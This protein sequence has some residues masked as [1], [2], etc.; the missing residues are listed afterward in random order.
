MIW[1][2]ER[3]S[4]LIGDIYDA[5]LDPSLWRGALR[6]IA[7]FVGGSASSICTTNARSVHV[8][9]HYHW[10]LQQSFVQ[11]Y[12]DNYVKCDPAAVGQF[13]F[14]VEDVY[15]FVDFLPLEEL[16]ETRF[17]KECLKPEGWIDRIGATLDKSATSFAA[18]V[19]FRNEQE[20]PVDEN[21][22]RRMR[23][24]VPHIRRAVLVGNVVDLHKGEASSLTSLFDSL[25][26]GVLL[27][28]ADAR[29]VFT[30]TAARAMLGEGDI[31]RDHGGKL[32]AID[33]AADRTLRDV[34]AA[35][36]NGDA[37]VGAEGVALPLSSASKEQWLA[38]ILPL[39]SGERRRAGSEHS[40]TAAVFVRKAQLETP[41]LMK[42]V[43]T[44]YR[45]TPTEIR[46]LQAL[47]EIGGVPSVA[48]ALGVSQ[49]TIR[50]HL[51]NLFAKTG[52][53][54]QADL[55]KLIASHSSPFNG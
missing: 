4:R 51:K 53:R 54:R 10:G 29:I 2:A 31:L 50:T 52:M 55:V 3:F 16:L 13:V 49:T 14:D 8:T 47:V 19:V 33:T 12:F 44:L 27:V 37:G 30:N 35:T 5:A 45:L 34:F 36:P 1:E 48:E 22:R 40:A 11:N 17:Y 9:S 43:A 20:G 39:T 32:S 18:C 15:S 41:P 26:D 42:T 28:D 38:H 25:A 21:M 7:G 24:V 23:L 46:V 6:D